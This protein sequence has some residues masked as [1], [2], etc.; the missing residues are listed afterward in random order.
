MQRLLLARLYNLLAL[1]AIVHLAT[2]Q[3]VLPVQK[4]PA[5]RL[6]TGMVHLPANLLPNEQAFTGKNEDG[7]LWRGRT[8]QLLQF[9]QLP[10][11]AAKQALQ[12]S[13][14]TLLQYLPENAYVASWPPGLPLATLQQLGARTAIPMQPEWKITWELQAA[15]AT[16]SVDVILQLLPVIEGSEAMSLLAAAGYSALS[17]DTLSQVVT[18]RTSADHLQHLAAWPW[19]AGLDPLPPP[20]KE[21]ASQRVQAAPSLTGNSLHRSNNLAAGP[22]STGRRYDGTDVVVSVGEEYDMFAHVDFAGRIVDK[23]INGTVGTHPPHVLGIL[24]GAGTGNQSALGHASGATGLLYKGNNHLRHVVQDYQTS[25]VRITNSSLGGGL[26]SRYGAGA[27]AIDARLVQYPFLMHVFSAGNSGRKTSTYGVG[28]NWEA[29]WSTLTG[30]AKQAKNALT[31]GNVWYN[32]RLGTQSS[33]GPTRDGRI[34]PDVC[35]M[36]IEVY[37]T[38]TSNRYAAKSGTSMAAPAVAGTLAQLIQAYRALNNGSE[39][40]AALLKATI[41][42]T[43]E[44]LGQPGPDFRH[45]YGRINALRAVRTLEQ[46]TYATAT[47]GQSDQRAH[48]ITVVPGQRELRVLL[49]WADPAP[50]ESNSTLTLVNDLDLALT[51]PDGTVWQPWVLQ[52]AN[53]RT[54]LGGAAVRGRDSLNNVEQITLT[55]PQPGTYLA[56]VRGHRVPLQQQTYYLTHSPGTEALE[57]T[58]P[59]GGEALVPGEEQ[60][61]RWDAPVGSTGTLDIHYSLDDGS[62]WQLIRGGV[63]IN[64]QLYRWMVPRTVTSGRSRIRLTQNTATSQSTASFTISGVPT[65]LRLDRHCATTSVLTWQA[66]S[67]VTQYE[68][69]RLRGQYLALVN[70]VTGTSSTV[71]A[72]P[73]VDEWYTVRAM[74]PSGLQS[75]RAM[76]VRRMAG[77]STTCP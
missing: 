42:N 38:V 61:I 31:V 72:T 12:T 19:V 15:R 52:T 1:M 47:L 76:A 3:A 55:A 65:Q 74:G 60:V 75:R 17:L 63:A 69:F 5:L 37:S 44:D 22:G 57:L 25:R 36:G 56:N 58:Y 13:G 26:N 54:A 30:D 39:A 46:R 32:D 9:T 48:P 43:A 40:P 66:V 23:Y 16:E 67:G 2:A 4:A 64:S 8:Y 11:E 49:Y 70:T 27:K 45:G 14:V 6:S 35:A 73:G 77:Q 34:K 41:L 68:I 59:V 33:R 28:T 24:L 53:T 50:T 10:N 20:E 18:L 21:E 71:P 7:T 62:S 29:G 51:A